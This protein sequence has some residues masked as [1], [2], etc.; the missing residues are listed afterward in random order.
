MNLADVIT[1]NTSFIVV[2]IFS[3]MSC[4]VPGFLEYAIVVMIAVGLL[5]AFGLIIW[6]AVEIYI[7]DDP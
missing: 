5:L 3:L 4:L 7:Y 6:R 2:V 1:S